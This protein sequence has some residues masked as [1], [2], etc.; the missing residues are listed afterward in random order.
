MSTLIFFSVKVIQAG[1]LLDDRVI[2]HGASYT[3]IAATRTVLSVYR[4]RSLDGGILVV[5]VQASIGIGPRGRGYHQLWQYTEVDGSG[6]TFRKAIG[7]VASSEGRLLMVCDKGV[8]IETDCFFEIH[9]FEFYQ[10]I[11]GEKKIFFFCKFQAIFLL[12][13]QNFQSIILFLS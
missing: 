7:R 9:I 13:K 8:F 2:V 3:C 4:A 12:K 5:D 1:G 6:A 11:L 10:D